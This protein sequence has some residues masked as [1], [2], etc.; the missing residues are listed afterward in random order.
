MM[1][2]IVAVTVSMLVCMNWLS[3]S[4]GCTVFYASN[5][6]VA[7]GGNNEDWHIPL[8]KLWFVPAT[9]ETHGV[10]YV[11]FS[12]HLAVQGGMN[13]QG[14]FFDFL[15][16]KPLEVARSLDF[17][18]WNGHP[19]K[20]IMQRCAT[21]DEAVRMFETHP[22][23]FL[24]RC[25]VFLGDAKGNSA[26]I[27]GAAVRQKTGRFQVATN[28]RPSIVPHKKVTCRRYHI[29]HKMLA[30]A[31]E[32]DVPL[33]RRICSAVHQEGNNSTLYS[34]IY[35]LKHQVIYL[36]HFHNFENVVVLDL[37]KELAKGERILEMPDLF[38]PTFVFEQFQRTHNGK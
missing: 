22:R 11:T 10:A 25:N 36:Y 18:R 13:D 23:G 3:I 34:T 28:L 2:R 14:L 31:S 24:K 7:L 21:V 6:K 17:E 8:T 5:D 15:A 30:D 20:I 1:R 38:P 16:V 29:A 37:K 19:L 32:F 12:N 26:I 9:A 4:H 33:F 35:D 27:E